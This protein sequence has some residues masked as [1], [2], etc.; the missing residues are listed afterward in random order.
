M[1]ILSCSKIKHSI[2]NILLGSCVEELPIKKFSASSFAQSNKPSEAR[3]NSSTC[4]KPSNASGGED[5]L[6]ID[7]GIIK[8]LS[9]ITTEGKIQYNLQYSTDEISWKYYPDFSGSTKVY[10]DWPVHTGSTE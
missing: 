1:S 6:E 2:C 4:W 9:A 7:L 8:V 3:F 5:Y 10:T